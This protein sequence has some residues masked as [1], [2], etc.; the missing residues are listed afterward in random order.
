MFVNE[1]LEW[2]DS[3]LKN[4]LWV[5]LLHAAIDRFVRLA[6]EQVFKSDKLKIGPGSEPP[7]QT[8]STLMQALKLNTEHSQWWLNLIVQ[9]TDLVTPSKIRNFM[10]MTE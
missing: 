7:D 1:N 5:Y 6:K 9:C 2:N 4:G 3:L 10:I 8:G